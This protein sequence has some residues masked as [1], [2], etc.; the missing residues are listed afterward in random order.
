VNILVVLGVAAVLGLLRYFRANLL[1]WAVAWWVG[2]FVL[3]RFGFIAPIPSSVMVRIMP[4]QRSLEK[5]GPFQGRPSS[6][7]FGP[8]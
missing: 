5:G 3:L 7:A 4:E 8:N 2:I 1:T 6:F